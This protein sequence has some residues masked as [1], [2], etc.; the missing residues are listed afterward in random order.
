M[1]CIKWSRAKYVGQNLNLVLEISTI[2]SFDMEGR[3]D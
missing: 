3:E 2:V 1:T